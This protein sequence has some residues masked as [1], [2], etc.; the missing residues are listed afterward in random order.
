MRAVL[1]LLV[2]G[3]LGCPAAGSAGEI[4]VRP[5]AGG[6]PVIGPALERAQPGDVIRLQKGVYRER[7]TLTKGVSLVGEEGAVLDP[8]EPF[9][10]QWRVAP[11]LGKGVY[12]AEVAQRPRTLFLEGKVLAEIDERRTGQEGPWF[13]KTLLA[14]GPRLS[15]FRFIRGIWMYRDQEKAIYLH[16]EDDGDPSARQWSVVWSTEPIVTIR[17]AVGASVRGLTLAHAYT[18]V[19]FVGGARDCSVQQCTVGPWDKTGIAIEDGAAGCLVAENQ[20]FRG[21]FEDWTPHDT[22]RER[23]ELWQVHKT[24]GFYD[25]VGIQL[26]RCG[27]GNRVH[28]NHV[29]ETFDGINLGDWDVES[30]D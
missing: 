30:L 26:F 18:G 4:V 8:S 13:W 17:G 14:T 28:A 16:L 24:A 21:P 19:A 22:S 11:E 2:A 7:I 3:A 9:R 20:V 5:D 15:G 6:R 1:P 12:R 23:Y 27:A 25:R 29:Y 10:P